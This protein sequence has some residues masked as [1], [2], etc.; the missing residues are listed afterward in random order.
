MTEQ[1]ELRPTDWVREH[2]ER[3]LKQGT[4]DG[5]GDGSV[6]LI[7]RYRSEVG[8]EA[9]APLMR[10]EEGERYA[11]VL[12]RLAPKHPTWYFDVSL[13]GRRTAIS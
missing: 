7:H 1:V 3:I 8:Q 11:M 12:R 13:H 10:V 6:F 4:T 9:E 2:T 5:V